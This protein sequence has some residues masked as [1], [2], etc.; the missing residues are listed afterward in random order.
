MSGVTPSACWNP[1]HWPVRPSPVCTSSMIEQ[2]LP[3]VAQRA[4]G[5]E[6]AGRRRQHAALALDRLEHHRADPLVHRRRERVEVAERDL[7]EPAGS[8]WNVSCFCGWP[9]AARVVS[10]RPWNE[11]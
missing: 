7:P 2:R 3:L 4:H 9:V 6:V 8:G 5:L 10:V 1:N 11:P